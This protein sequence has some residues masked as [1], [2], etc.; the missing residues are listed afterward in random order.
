MYYAYLNM[1]FIYVKSVGY[2][3][4]LDLQQI[5]HTHCE[6]MI[7]HIASIKLHVHSLNGQFMAENKPKAKK[8]SRTAAKA[9]LNERCI[10]TEAQLP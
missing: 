10:L 2:N 9:C 7:T 1:D 8:D 3:L 6:C 4:T 5:F